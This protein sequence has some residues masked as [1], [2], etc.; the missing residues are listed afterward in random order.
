MASRELSIETQD[1][2]RVFRVKRREARGQT[3]E[4][5]AHR[6]GLLDMQTMH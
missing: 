3:R 1:L 6:R 2:T 4:V 5:V